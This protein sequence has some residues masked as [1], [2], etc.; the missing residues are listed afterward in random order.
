MGA[1]SYMSQHLNPLGFSLGQQST[2]EARVVPEQTNVAALL[3]KV[4]VQPRNRH[5]W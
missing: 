5:T 3:Q 1:V 4:P 2:V